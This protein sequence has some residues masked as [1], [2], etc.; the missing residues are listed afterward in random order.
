MMKTIFEY[1]LRS[2][3]KS[4]RCC[5]A[6]TK[7]II[8]KLSLSKKEAEIDTGSSTTAVFSNVSGDYWDL[9]LKAM[10]DVERF[11][12]RAESIDAFLIV[13]P[14]EKSRL[15]TVECVGSIVGLLHAMRQCSRIF[16]PTDFALVTAQL[17]SWQP[18]GKKSEV[19]KGI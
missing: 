15:I 12:S 17:E 13:T 10:N 18:E 9:V 7:P 4:K 16:E 1:S 14:N 3:A 19:L 5:F 8:A 6:V 2:A 11:L